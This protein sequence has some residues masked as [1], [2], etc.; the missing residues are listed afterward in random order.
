MNRILSPVAGAADHGLQG[1]LCATQLGAICWRVSEGEVQILLITSR[2]TGRWVIPKGWPIAGKSL[3]EAA[4]VEA[5]EE[6]GV[7]GMVQPTLWGRFHYD[8]VM[9]DRVAGDGVM[10]NGVMGA[11]PSIPC[12][13][14]VFGL[15]VARLK[16]RFPE[17]KQRRRKWFTPEQAQLLVAEPEL[18]ELLRAL[19]ENPAFLAVAKLD[20]V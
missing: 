5:W 7:E 9:G 16:R 17:R 20:P 19:P 18:I 11:K 13:V 2:D 4:A 3:A 15:R 10:G 1:E 12:V 8:K 6:A 14:A